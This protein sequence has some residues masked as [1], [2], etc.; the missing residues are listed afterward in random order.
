MVP[1]VPLKF[2]SAS[3]QILRRAF[4]ETK[5]PYSLIFD[6]LVTQGP[7]LVS[8]ATFCLDIL[9]LLFFG[10]HTV[11]E[12]S[13]VPTHTV[14]VKLVSALTVSVSGFNC[15]SK[16]DGRSRYAS[17]VRLLFLGKLGL[18]FERP[19]V[20]DSRICDSPQRNVSSIVANVARIAEA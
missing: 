20:A 11:R 4:Q 8:A 9:V 10:S 5:A 2:C 13:T 17:H 12:V 6:A 3:S 16:D 15:A 7:E 19:F 1:T 14:A 18:T